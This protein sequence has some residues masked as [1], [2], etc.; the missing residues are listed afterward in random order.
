MGGLCTLYCTV[1]STLY[2]TVYHAGWPWWPWVVTM[3]RMSFSRCSYR[4]ESGVPLVARLVHFG[5]FW[6]I[7]ADGHFDHDLNIEVT[8]S[9]HQ[10]VKSVKNAIFD[11]FGHFWGSGSGQ[12]PLFDQNRPTLRGD[13]L[14]DT[15][16]KNDT[17][18]TMS[19]VSKMTRF[20]TF[21]TG[22]PIL[23]VIWPETPKIRHSQIRP[24]SHRDG[25]KKCHK[26]KMSR[27]S[28]KFLKK[29]SKNFS[30][31]WFLV[32]FGVTGQFWPKTWSKWPL[33]WPFLCSTKNHHFSDGFFQKCPKNHWKMP[34]KRAFLKKMHSKN[35]QLLPEL[36]LENDPFFEHFRVT[37]LGQ[38]GVK[39]T[40]K[41]VQ[42]WSKNGHFMPKS[43]KFTFWQNWQIVR[44]PWA[45]HPEKDGFFQ[46]WPFLQ[47]WPKN[48]PFFTFF[49]ILKRAYRRIR[50]WDHRMRGS[51]K[52]CSKMTP[53]WPKW[54]IFD[55]FLTHFWPLF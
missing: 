19:K 34:K 9:E 8:T 27:K 36:A 55:P 53:K 14:M 17:F 1:Y 12:K 51:W 33:Y 50:D 44:R 45:I 26:N 47:K 10:N 54:P 6:D 42:K 16:V 43:C 39:N 46:K 40:P 32:I 48:D 18:Q 49:E 2:S 11:H 38:R 20:D 13:F 52:K 37:P 5:H 25:S 29:P 15:C 28:P 22:Y 35:D 24:G 7:S 31:S 41:G 21:L 23:E 30:K 3:A 4:N